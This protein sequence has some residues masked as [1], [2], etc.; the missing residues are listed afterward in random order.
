M[1]CCA[2]LWMW[3]WQAFVSRM[4]GPIDENDLSFLLIRMAM[5]R[6]LGLNNVLSVWVFQRS[7]GNW[8]GQMWRH[9]PA[10]GMTWLCA[11]DKTVRSGGEGQDARQKPKLKSMDDGW[12]IVTRWR[13]S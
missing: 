10:P 2:V 1:L 9:V 4:A 5:L 3:S 8:Y 6:C 12:W 13:M 7:G 11:C